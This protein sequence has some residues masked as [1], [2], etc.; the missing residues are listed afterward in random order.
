MSIQS[1][2]STPKFGMGD[3]SLYGVWREY[4]QIKTELPQLREQQL[5]KC[6]AVNAG[7]NGEAKLAVTNSE[8]FSKLAEELEQ[9]EARAVKIAEVFSE[10]DSIINNVRSAGFVVKEETASGIGRMRRDF[11]NKLVN[12]GIY[13]RGQASKALENGAS[14]NEVSTEPDRDLEKQVAILQEAEAK[15]LAAL[16]KL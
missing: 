12:Q 3:D 14:I 2:F 16:A 11:E 10:I 9:S 1:Y 8:L 15:C 7:K 5:L 13:K 6:C 4:M